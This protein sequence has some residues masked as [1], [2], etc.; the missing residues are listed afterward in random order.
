MLEWSK[1][2]RIPPPLVG[3]FL[4]TQYSK[5]ELND[6]IDMTPAIRM[7]DRFVKQV[8]A[9]LSEMG[10]PTVDYLPLFRRNN[11]QNMMVDKWE[12]HP[13]ALANQLYAEGLLDAITSRNLIQ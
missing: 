8:G 11:R 5:A 3:L 7:Q 4:S 9:T 1:A 10:I 13:N 2:R 12:G 6:F